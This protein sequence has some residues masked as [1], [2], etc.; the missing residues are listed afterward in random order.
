MSSTAARPGRRSALI[1]LVIGLVGAGV[2]LALSRISPLTGAVS[3]YVSHIPSWAFIGVY[4][5]GGLL[6]VV[7]GLIGLLRGR[8]RVRLMAVVGILLSLYVALI[9]VAGWAVSTIQIFPPGPFL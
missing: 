8:G 4:L 7:S 1:S 5:I 3:P 2:F 6:G 9:G